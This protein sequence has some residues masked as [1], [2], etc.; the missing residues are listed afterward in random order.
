MTIDVTV[1][2]EIRSSYLLPL[3]LRVE[4]VVLYHRGLR[5]P[6]QTFI[7]HAVTSGDLTLEI[8]RTITSRGSHTS[9]NALFAIFGAVSTSKETVRQ[10]KA[11]TNAQN[12]AASKR[13]LNPQAIMVADSKKSPYHVTSSLTRPQRHRSLHVPTFQS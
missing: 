2:R 13:V 1:W 12:L 6:E 9:L 4:R 11:K 8:R 3:G 5:H 7:T 10:N